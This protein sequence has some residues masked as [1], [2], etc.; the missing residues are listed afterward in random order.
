MDFEHQRVSSKAATVA[1]LEFENET[2]RPN[3]YNFLI[4]LLMPS[5]S[6]TT[7]RTAWS[8]TTIQEVV[9]SC[10]L[11]RYQLTHRQLPD[12]LDA[13]VPEFMARVPQDVID[14]QPL[15]YRRVRGDQFVLYS[16]GRNERDDGGQIAWT[17]DKPPRQDQQQGDWVWFSQP[18]PQPSAKER[19]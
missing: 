17:K 13:L 19:K 16:I 1:A 11:E 5:I 4:G 18:Q 7:R 14:G 2:M 6:A 3:P 8:Q 12:T 10:A 9:V 15:R